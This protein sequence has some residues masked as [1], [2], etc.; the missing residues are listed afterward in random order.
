MDKKELR[1]KF[2]DLRESLSEKEWFEYSKSIC[3]KLIDSSF[4]K[5]SQRIAFYYPVNKEVNLTIAIEEALKQGKE[6]FLPKTHLKE[7]RLSFHK[8]TD[9]ARLSPGVFGIFEPPSIDSP[10]EACELD[11]ILVPGL[12][13]DLKKYRLG[14]GGGFYDRFLKETKALKIGIAFSFQII[15]KLPQD[16][17]DEKMDYILTEEGFF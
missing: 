5:N 11:L 3:Q 10:I 4:F 14:Y 15:E 9:L 2:K 1:K 17:W 16:P 6:I 8:V 7:K 13:F 12:A